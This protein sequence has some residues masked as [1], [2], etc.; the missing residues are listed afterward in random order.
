M[1][2]EETVRPGQRLYE[3]DLLRFIAALGIVMLHYTFRGQSTAYDFAPHLGR[4]AQYGYLGVDLFF[5]ISGMVVLMS[6]WGRTG[7]EFL[8]SRISRL[9]PAYWL[10]VT[11]TAVVVVVVRPPWHSE[12]TVTQYLANLTMFQSVAGIPHVEGVYW[13]LWVEWRFYLLL[14]GFT[15]IGITVRRTQ[16]LL[17][18]WLACGVAM[19]ALPV[20]EVVR[21]GLRLVVQPQLCHYFIAG[22]CL[23][24]VHRHGMTLSRAALLVACFVNAVV[25]AP[26]RFEERAG[27]TPSLTVVTLILA[28]I[29][30]VMTLVATGGTRWLR[31]PWLATAGA[32]TYPLYLIHSTA[33]TVLFNALTAVLNPWLALPLVVATMCALSWLIATQVENRC[34]P[35]LTARL[36]GRARPPRTSPA[37]S[38]AGSSLS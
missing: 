18:G 13:T 6:V 23:Y 20:P 4:V 25:Q 21:A 9:Y 17:W 8:A 11:L 5:V 19:Q 32:M 7:R 36:A 3:I 26:P 31:R 29:F 24:L 22:M 27:L 14:L 12:V 2:T 38:Y 10:A 37:V 35:L 33:G 16:W 15:L 30:T 1:D 34:R 28:G